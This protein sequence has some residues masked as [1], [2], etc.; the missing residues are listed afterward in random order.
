LNQTL[1]AI[2]NATGAY[3]TFNYNM[4]DTAFNYNMTDGVGTGNE[5]WNQSLAS[6]LYQIL[7]DQGLST[8]DDVEFN[9]LIVDGFG[10]GGYWNV[11]EFSVNSTDLFLLRLVSCDADNEKFETDAFGTLTCGVNQ[12][13]DISTNLNVSSNNVTST[14][15]IIFRSGGQICSGT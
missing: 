11:D 7:E 3:A 13:P 8:T 9:Q 5:S 12:N 6:T 15:C 10:G 2:N 4:T 14:D 1:G